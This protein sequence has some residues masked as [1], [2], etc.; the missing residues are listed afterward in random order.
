[1]FS[2]RFLILF[3]FLAFSLPV[4]S[5]TKQEIQK[6]QAKVE[7]EIA[8]LN[9]LQANVKNDQSATMEKLSF[10]DE[11]IKKV[12]ELM[13][14]LTDEIDLLESDI[15]ENKQR[16]SKLAA[17]RQKL[18]DLYAKLVYETWKRKN[19]RLDKL[20]F[21][22][23][24]TDFAQAYARYRYFEQ[25]QDYS[26]Q[27]IR[28]IAR[29]NDSLRVVNSNLS[30]LLSQK[31]DV[32]SRLSSQ[33]SQLIAEMNQANALVAQLKKKQ[34]EIDEKLKAE[35]KSREKYEIAI[36]KLVDNQVAKPG[37][38][39]STYKLTPEQQLISNDFVKN[40]G[41]LPWP[42]V[43]GIVSEHHGRNISPFA[44]SV[45]KVNSGITIT[46][47]GHAEVLAVFGGMVLEI[48][49]VDGKNIFVAILHGDFLTLYDNLIE[50][51]VRV[52][53][54]V[55]AK[56]RIGKLVM[57]KSGNSSFN[58]QIWKKGAKEPFDPELWLAK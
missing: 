8:F 14:F 40:K 29:S 6:K 51:Y 30:E 37:S 10:I 33:N 21:I 44:S 24:S 54:T 52:G 7:K 23:S 56:Q 42:V 22:F 36:R 31:N 9:K 49:P 5:Q 39:N 50:L 38:N 35:M 25:I 27:Q 32:Q 17:D 47:S 13:S 57:S 15:R 43:E 18:L 58:F 55:T 19:N 48:K 20:A 45:E 53:E 46:T 12:K 26:K 34:K 1:M 2:T 41:H 28:F 11:K 3:L 16:Q 4:F